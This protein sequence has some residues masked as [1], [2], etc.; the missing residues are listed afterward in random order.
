[1]NV[2]RNLIKLNKSCILL[3]AGLLATNLYGVGDDEFGNDAFNLKDTWFQQEMS[4]SDKRERAQKRKREYNPLEFSWKNWKQIRHL[5]FR[6]NK[7]TGYYVTDEEGSRFPLI[8]DKI[9]SRT[10][11]GI[12]VGVNVYVTDI[13]NTQG[14]M[15]CHTD[16]KQKIYPWRAKSNF[17]R[18]TKKS[19]RKAYTCEVYFKLCD[20]DT[21]PIK[22]V[23]G[24]LISLKNF[25]QEEAIRNIPPAPQPPEL[26]MEQPN[27]QP[28]QLDM[29]QYQD[30][31]DASQGRQQEEVL[32]NIPPVP[33]ASELIMEQ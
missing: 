12:K 1:M 26:I 33:Q 19:N 21:Y 14:F 18:Y 22:N 3:S 11:S 29:S 30:I 25:E 13:Q 15:L 8:I 31:E 20:I 17:V 2:D 16:D 7:Y 10:K 4:S 27:N 32:R 5:F 23:P 24:V 9:E 28:G 6:Q